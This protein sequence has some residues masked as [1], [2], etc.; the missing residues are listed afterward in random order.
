V[1]AASSALRLGGSG[2]HA[3]Q[4]ILQAG[5]PLGQARAALIMLH[6]RGGSSGDMIALADNLVMPG[7]AFLAP[8]A[9]DSVWY[10]NRY[11]TPLAGNEPWLSSALSGI[12]SLIELAGQYAILPERLILT[13]FSQGA[14]LSTEYAVR[15][16]R[17]YGGLAALA[18][19]LIGPKDIPR[20]YP[21]S[22]AGMPA[23]LGCSDPDTYFTPEWIH[24]SAAALERLDARIDIRLYPNLGHRINLDM[25]HALRAMME[26]I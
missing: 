14:C 16:A 20:D 22:L 5:E 19:G 23:F 11:N 18:G 4:P 17:R 24:Y 2:P 1:S 3:G 13:G 6:G 10:P 25:I 21:G 26:G 7:F 8:Q 12:D 15:N 9:A